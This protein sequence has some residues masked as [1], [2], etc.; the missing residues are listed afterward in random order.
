MNFRSPMDGAIFVPVSDDPYAD[1]RGPDD[2]LLA[3]AVVGFAAGRR[4]TDEG[5]RPAATPP[6][7]EAKSPIANLME[8]IYA[9]LARGPA[10]ASPAS[11]A[12]RQSGLAAAADRLIAVQASRRPL[13][14]LLPDEAS[15]SGLAAAADRLIAAQQRSMANFGASGSGLKAALDRLRAGR[16]RALPVAP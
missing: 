2:R 5:P 8:R 12:P 9:D 15:A 4:A 13:R 11:P 3:A 1:L 7:R 16:A 10:L 6:K 14:T